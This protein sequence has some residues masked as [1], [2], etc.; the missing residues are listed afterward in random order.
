MR[1]SFFNN[2][3]RCCNTFL[4]YGCST[5][6]VCPSQTSIQTRG[7]L[8]GPSPPSSQVCSASWWR[9]APP[10][11]ASRPL[12]TRWEQTVNAAHSDDGTVLSQCVTHSLFFFFFQK[13][14]LSA[15]SLAFNLKDKVFCELFPDVVDVSAHTELVIFSQFIVPLAL[16]SPISFCPST[17]RWSR[18]RRFK[19][20]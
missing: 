1:Q 20:S 4:L 6:Y 5:G 12:I 13:R 16:Y 17:R 3:S 9:K 2:L 19:K 8:H 18:N 11:A 7:T 10:S 15:Q 14:Q